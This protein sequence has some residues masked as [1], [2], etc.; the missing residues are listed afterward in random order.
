[1][2][3]PVLRVPVALWLLSL[4]LVLPGCQASSREAPEPATGGPEASESA[5]QPLYGFNNSLLNNIHPLGDGSPSAGEILDWMETAEDLIEFA[6][7]FGQCAAGGFNEP[8][9]SARDLV[10]RGICYLFAQ[11]MSGMLIFDPG[12]PFE[13]VCNGEPPLK[14]CKYDP[15]TQESCHSAFNSE[16]PINCEG[17]WT[18]PNA[19]SYGPCIPRNAY[20]GDPGCFC[21]YIPVCVGPTGTVSQPTGSAPWRY[22]QLGVSLAQS[23]EKNLIHSQPGPF[24]DYVSFVGFR[25]HRRVMLELAP[26]ARPDELPEGYNV[27]DAYHANDNDPDA[28]YL[29]GLVT[30][31]IQRVFSGIPNLQNRWNHVSGRQWTEA[32]KTAYLSGVA[33]PDLTLRQCV[34]DFG[35]AM[36]QSAQPDVYALLSVP[37]EGETNPDCAPGWVGGAAIGAAPSVTVSASTS[38]AS[39]TVAPAISDPNASDNAQGSYAVEVDWGDGRVQGWA[40]VAANPAT[41][42]YTHT[43]AAAG[44]YSVK[45]SVINTSGLV[46]SALTQVT[47][48]EGSGQPVPPSIQ[49]VQF[50]L[51]AAVKA[52]THGRVR[53]DVSAT[54]GQGESHS[55]GYLWVELSG[56]S[57]TLVTVPLDE[58]MPLRDLT[59]LVS[60]KLTPA[61]YDGSSVSSRELIL[62]AVKLRPHGAPGATTYALTN[63]DVKVYAA[64]STTP[65]APVMEAG[66]GKLR[67]PVQNADIVITVP[68]S[69]TPDPSAAYGCRPVETETPLMRSAGGGCEDIA[70]GLVFTQLPGTMTWHDAVWDSALEGNAAPDADDHGRVNDYP[71]NYPA[72]GPDASTVNACHSLVQGGYS[73][74]RLPTE[75][76]LLAIAGVARAGTY[77]PYGTAAYAWTSTSYD[78]A[79][80]VLRHLD[81]ASRTTAAKA[82][83]LHATVCV[84]SPPP[85]AE[86]GC[87]VPADGT[88]V[89]TSGQGG[90]LDTRPGGLVWSKA[91]VL[92]KSWNAAVWGS[93][94]AGNSPP[95][96]SDG[97]RVNDYAEAMVPGTPDSSTENY[98]HSLVEGGHEDWRLPT[99]AELV[100][101]K[102][103]ALA[104]KYFAFDTSEAVWSANTA[105]TTTSATAVTLV[106]TRSHTTSAKTTLHRVV[107]VRTPATVVAAD[108]APTAFTAP[109]AV[110]TRETVAFTWTVANGG[111]QEAPAS[112]RDGVYLSTDA[113]LS[114]DDLLV[115]DQARDVALAAGASYSASKS[116][117]MP[118]V[119]AGSYY[120]L[121]RTDSTAT[122]V[123]VDDANNTWTAVAVSV[124]TPD[125]VPTAFTAPSV[126]DVREVVTFTWT[127]AN[128]GTGTAHPSWNDQVYLS[129]DEVYGMGDVQVLSQSRSTALAAGESYSV[130]KTATLPNVAAGDY[131]LLFRTDNGAALYEA[132]EANNGWA[133]MPVTLLAGDLVAAGFT[134]PASADVRESVSFTWTVRNDGTGDAQPNWNDAI[135]LS[136]DETYGTGD[137]QVLSVSRTAALAPGAGYSVTRAAT[138]PNVAAGSYFLL[139]RV[140][141]N[142]GLL[143]ADETNNGWTAVPVTLS[144][145]DL[146]PT[147]FTA[148]ASADVRETVTFTWTVHNNGTGGAQPSWND[149]VFL[150]TDE[151]YGTGDVQVTSVSRGT[152]VAPGASYSVTKTA[153]LPNVAAGSYFFLFRTDHNANLLEADETNNGW[154][155]VPVTVTSAD[156]VPGTLTAPAS[157]NPG[158]SFTVSWTVTNASA[159]GDA[160]PS[161]TDQLY[162]STDATCCTGD[163]SLGTVNRNTALAPGASYTAS[164]TVT[165]PATLAPGSYQLFLSVDRNAALQESDE[166]NNVISVPFTV[167]P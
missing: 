28:R 98:C 80:A 126:A 149:N 163:T 77:L 119:P 84:R 94:L 25:P 133:A 90:C 66:T 18:T 112:W 150:S 67:L 95:D 154:T 164:R 89:F 127:V 1:M 100:A 58:V 13:E 15:A 113:T 78:A 139:F 34:G 47:V 59:D 114:R 109:S 136:T 111:S 160:H 41:Q 146:A 166:T 6:E 64:S 102:G 76:E 11:Q 46:G 33:D 118:G 115:T 153:T 4:V 140:D 60:L 105:S 7:E 87:R 93:E 54:D 138:M 162:L 103:A 14:C 101:V 68:S 57:G 53:V 26:F 16:A 104:A 44:T 19:E 65:T 108:L 99:V 55:L 43:Y 73:D 122:K 155:A 142:A 79:N 107:C 45:V 159:S 128:A 49:T 24:I 120:F 91:S 32:E 71:G 132:D 17:N 29:R 27:G 75:N 124:T 130:T 23:I 125:V 131:F 56:A 22:N 40:Y 52:N 96:A 37:L 97:A 129:T 121:F 123:E 152:A 12:I 165:V 20:P 3:T 69:T 42:A 38:G 151:T 2:H 72:A 144:S 30:L 134:A 86:H 9:C 35:L 39:V 106:D 145:G 10:W 117:A 62:S 21:N 5:P 158:A 143:E 92:P 31:A 147:A 167:G 74:W 83:A 85:P 156:L 61:H 157:A 148:P 63:R 110:S 48:A 135:Y 141:H 116:V 50:E 8:G 82:T 137:V 36:L 161:W 88:T 70:T 81:S 51:E